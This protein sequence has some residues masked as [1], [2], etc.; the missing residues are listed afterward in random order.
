MKIRTGFVSN[1]SSSSFVI[2]S[3]RRLTKRM[4][5][6][7]FGVP[8]RHPLRQMVGGMIDTIFSL[9]KPVK[10]S[11][12]WEYFEDDYRESL[13]K[14][15]KFVY[16]GSF[17]DEGNGGET[18]ESLLCWTNLNVKGKDFSIEHKSGY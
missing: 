13:L 12:D 16:V 17:S 15:G 1:S 9:A 3:N 10:E 18:I 4:L 11:E 7:T 5:I 6:E 2:T 14:K 8:K